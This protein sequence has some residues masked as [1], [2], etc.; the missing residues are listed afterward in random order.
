[1]AIGLD[2]ISRTLAG[3]IDP[4]EEYPGLKGLRFEPQCLAIGFRRL[5]QG[6]QFTPGAGEAKPRIVQFSVDP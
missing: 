3:P 2:R 6:T 5:V 4:A 1:L